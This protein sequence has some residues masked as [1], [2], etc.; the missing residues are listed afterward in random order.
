M[1]EYAMQATETSQGSISDQPSIP[2]IP[3]SQDVV[4]LIR[5]VPEALLERLLVSVAVEPGGVLETE[6]GGRARIHE[7]TDRLAGLDDE[8]LGA[9]VA[10]AER[11]LEMTDELGQESL[12]SCAFDQDLLSQQE[13][14]EARSLWLFLNEPASFRRAEEIRYADNYR[15]GR[16]WDGFVG[17]KDA[18]VS[19]DPTRHQ[20]FRDR[21]RSWFRSGQV[22]VEMFERTRPNL[23]EKDS[24]L[25]Q[26]AVYREGLPESFLE[27]KEGDL[28]QRH[29]RPVFELVL[30]YE[31]DTGVIEVV[32]PNRDSREEVARAFAETL[33]GQEINNARISL[34]QY[35][36]TSL[37]N[38]REFPT[39]MEDGI[40]EVR[41]TVLTLRPG[42]GGREDV[43]FRTNGMSKR[44]IH[45][46]L[47]D[48]FERNNP[49]T[50][51]FTIRRARLSVKFHPEKGFGR[52]KTIHVLLTLPNGCSLKSKSER[53]RL[54]CE[55]YL[56]L[57]G[58]VKEV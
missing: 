8:P 9:L 19:G 44:S 43:E 32:A 50:T 21:V 54:I 5:H 20:A 7:L 41:V 4:R 39:E 25:I 56:P 34:R 17:P 33:L 15:N 10:D 42:D 53:E 26:L 48:W 29:R 3:F 27:F 35:D 47:F 37:M 51:G 16:M 55:K 11:I 6:L 52:G 28:R 46:C 57:W 13:S 58:L 49:L 1:T 12:F 14:A 23:E 18:V 40:A 45:E 2:T 36:L 38:D 31:A 24:H 22:K 30:T